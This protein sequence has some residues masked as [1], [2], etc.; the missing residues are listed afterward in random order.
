MKGFEK[1]MPEITVYTKN[2]CVQCKM[3]KKFLEQMGVNY[4]T[5]NIDEQPEYVDY[6][7]ARGHR[8]TPVVA[9]D[10]LEE[11]T[12]FRPDVLKKAIADAKAA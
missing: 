12:G 6:L 3:T 11:F 9:I 7:K 8:Q 10:G 4:K 2:D 5:I 1:I